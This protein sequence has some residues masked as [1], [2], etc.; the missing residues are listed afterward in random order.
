MNKLERQKEM[1]KKWITALRSNEYRQGSNY[2]CTKNNDYYQHCC[3]GVLCDLI[4]LKQESINDKGVV[5]YSISPTSKNV[6]EENSEQ[7]GIAYLPKIAMEAVGLATHDGAFDKTSLKEKI[8]ENSLAELN[9][10]GYSFEYIADV[11]ESNPGLL[12][13]FE[14]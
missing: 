4:D 8:K 7:I 12:F 6:I 13:E 2:L 11:I 1:R 3:L 14:R 5:Y 9:D 10:S